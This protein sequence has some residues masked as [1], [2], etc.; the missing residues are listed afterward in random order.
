MTDTELT[1]YIDEWLDENAWRLDG[2]L[3]DFVLDVRLMAAGSVPA[4]GSHEGGALRCADIRV[5]ETC[6][7]DTQLLLSLRSTVAF[8][9]QGRRD[10][11][12][13]SEAP[14]FT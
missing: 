3:L 8:G 11:A 6:V 9:R 4:S 1:R 5:V 7:V 2:R 10:R 13:I 14:A 12:R